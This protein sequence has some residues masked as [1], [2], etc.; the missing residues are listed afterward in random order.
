MQAQNEYKLKNNSINFKELVNHQNVFLLDLSETTRIDFDLKLNISDISIFNIELM[1]MDRTSVK[2]VSLELARKRSCEDLIFTFVCFGRTLQV[3]VD[4][5]KRLD[6]NCYYDTEKGIGGLVING[7][8]RELEINVPLTYHLNTLRLKVGELENECGLNILEWI[9]SINIRN[10][11]VSV[12]KIIPIID[13]STK[14]TKKLKSK[15][16]LLYQDISSKISFIDHFKNKPFQLIYLFNKSKIIV[17]KNPDSTKSNDIGN[18]LDKYLLNLN[19]QDVVGA[20]HYMNEYF[21]AGNSLS[22]ISSSQDKIEI[23][24]SKNNQNYAKLAEELIQVTK[25]NHYHANTVMPSLVISCAQSLYSKISPLASKQFLDAYKQSNNGNGDYLVQDVEFAQNRLQ[26][27]GEIIH[28]L[29]K[30]LALGGL[31][32][33]DFFKDKFCN[34]PFDDFEIRS[35]GEVF[36]CCPSYL[37]HSI[38]NIFKVDSIDE[39]KQSQN[40]TDIQNSIVK[41]DFRYCS[42][43]KCNKIRDNLDA[44]PDSIPVKYAPKDFRL[45]YDPT[46][47]LW[48]PSCRKEKIVATGELRDRF[49]DLTDNIVLPMLKEAETCMMNGYGD[50]FASRACRKILKDVNPV[51]FPNLKFNFITNGVLL[52]E[53]EWNKF[54][55][56]SGMVKSIRVSLDAAKKDTY[57]IVRLGGDWDVLTENLKFLSKLRLSGEIENFMISMVIQKENYLEMELFAELGAQLNCDTVIYE[58]IINWNSYDVDDFDARAVHYSS[59]PEHKKFKDELLKIQY[60]LNEMNRIKAESGSSFINTNSSI[61]F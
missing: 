8:E 41:Q 11:Q 53:S 38:G 20:A 51:E 48:C 44:V 27:E 18:N 17:Y 45:S 61:N 34:H 32:Y 49:M 16:E 28:P 6:V 24:F 36:V 14:I 26:E 21:N 59:H 50:I 5:A 25:V 60:K 52:T 55:N 15:F 39:L 30:N 57:D 35:D 7:N 33:L 47:N 23:G 22:I 58:P 1:N 13:A 43:M 37:P 40:L 31:F 3:Q 12:R 56:I 2:G 19:K 29:I 9:E 54:P 4:F 10:V 46:C 42:W